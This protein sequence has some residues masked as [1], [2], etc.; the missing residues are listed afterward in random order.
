MVVVGIS[1]R[2]VDGSY[3]VGENLIKKIK[4]NNAFPIIILPGF[5]EALEIILALCN[6]FIILGGNIWH[7][8]DELIIK[9]AIKH[10]IPLLG[11][12]AGMQAIANIKNFCGTKDS[13]KTILIGNDKHYSLDKYS[14]CI[15]ITSNFLSDILESNR[16]MVNSRH[17]FTVIKEDYFMVDAYSDDGV[18][19]AIHFPYKRFILGVQWHPE[20]LDDEFSQKLFST[21]I[22]QCKNS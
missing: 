4:E 12:C 1:A 15:N 2:L 11:I 14:H 16:I 13:D 21:F 8:T 19:E 7:E 10:D 5:A 3:K 22:E 17:K 18:I 20:N 6:G 9:Y